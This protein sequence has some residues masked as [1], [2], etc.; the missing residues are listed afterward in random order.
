MSYNCF[1]C[2]FS[3][4]IQHWNFDFLDGFLQNHAYIYSSI[5]NIVSIF[6]APLCDHRHRICD[7]LDNSNFY[8]Q[9]VCSKMASL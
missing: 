3:L 8:L 9:E 7:I 2:S 6:F 5:Y 1:F 4:Q